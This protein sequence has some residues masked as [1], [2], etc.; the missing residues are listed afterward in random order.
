MSWSI[1]LCQVCKGGHVLV[2]EVNWHDTQGRQNGQCDTVWPGEPGE[3]EAGERGSAGDTPRAGASSVAGLREWARD[4]LSENL[5]QARVKEHL[6]DIVDIEKI[7]SEK[8]VKI[9]TLSF[10]ENC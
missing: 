8:I 2:T 9:Y 4:V 3:A 1:V 10:K 7:S 5:G 6:F